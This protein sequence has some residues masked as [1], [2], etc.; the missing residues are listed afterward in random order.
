VADR[1]C[2]VDVARRR[3]I[4]REAKPQRDDNDNTEHEKTREDLWNTAGAREQ[5]NVI[6]PPRYRALVDERDEKDP[7]EVMDRF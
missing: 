5:R 6:Q 7:H 4:C 1:E 3:V 2:E